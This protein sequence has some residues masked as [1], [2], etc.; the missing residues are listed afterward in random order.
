M[1]LLVREEIEL[2]KA[3]VSEKVTSL[4]KGAVVALAAGI[5]FVTGLLFL[6]DGAAWAFYDYLFDHVVWGF[7]IVA[8]ILFV[9]GG[10]AG[11]LAARWLGVGAPS[12]TM[13]I[14]E[15][16]AIKATLTSS[17]AAGASAAGTPEG[18]THGAGIRG[19]E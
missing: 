2:A 14:E 3:E 10:L 13:A 4:I 15:A 17:D 5:F 1:S 11:W 16:Q 7:L 9:L 18:E 12:P 19:D 6:L 8:L